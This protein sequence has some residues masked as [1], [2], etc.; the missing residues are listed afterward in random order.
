MKN[1]E[2]KMVEAVLNEVVEVGGNTAWDDIAGLEGV[3]EVIR[4]K[5]QLL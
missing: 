5:L 3:K 4:V 2:R 1:I